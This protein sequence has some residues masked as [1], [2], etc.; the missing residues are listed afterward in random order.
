MIFL[1]EIENRKVTSGWSRQT[2]GNWVLHILVRL[3]EELK[4]GFVSSYFLRNYNVLNVEG[5]IY[6]VNEHVHSV[7]ESNLDSQR[8]Q[9]LQN[10]KP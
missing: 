5:L 3:L 8:Q 2:V 10:N 4:R 6:S 9:M 7:D 1:R